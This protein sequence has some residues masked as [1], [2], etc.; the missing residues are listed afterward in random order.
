[1][2]FSFNLI[3][4]PWIPC[5]PVDGSS[6]VL[7]SLRQALVGARD[8]REIY[9][10]SPLVTISLYR[11]LLAVIYRACVPLDIGA[12]IGWLRS[13]LPRDRIEAYLKKWHDR[14]DLFCESHPFSQIAGME[15]NNE[16]NLS[17][18]AVEI[19]SGNN[20]TLFDHN[21]DDKIVFFSPFQAGQLLLAV[22]SFA[23]GGGQG[24]KVLIGD[25]EFKATNLAHGVALRG[26]TNWLAADSLEHSLLLNC[27]PYEME[28]IDPSD[29]LPS[30]EL[31]KPHALRDQK[32]DKKIVRHSV[33][34]Y[35]DRYTWQ[36]RLIRLLPEW[37]DGQIVVG[38]MYF[39]QGR[40]IDSENNTYDPMKAYTMSKKGGLLSVQMNVGK[41]M[42]RNSHALFPG[43]RSGMKVPLISNL[44]SLLT[45]YEVVERNGKCVMNS[46]DLVRDSQKAAKLLLWRHDRMPVRARMFDDKALVE[47]LDIC[48][49]SAETAAKQLLRSVNGLCRHYLALGEHKPDPADVRKLADSLQAREDY[50]AALEPDFYAFLDKL[51]ETPEAAKKWWIAQVEVRQRSA[52]GAAVMRLGQSLRANVAAARSALIFDPFKKNELKK[53]KRKE[54]AS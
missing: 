47:I 3:D 29:D 11:L 35:A 26:A 28:E 30:W 31:D 27:V 22:Q 12:V 44:L 7:V 51:P 48:L 4:E 46:V 5:L 49:N 15:L 18:L 24:C 39:T 45:K 52:Y 54:V 38:E 13:G 1:M 8:F 42:W 23:V 34:G 9:S 14:F 25:E 21:Y 32:I 16:T 50:W 37:E 19:S 2:K 20:P 53:S 33:K 10:E 41:A 6:T 17:R 36:S 43:A 40:S